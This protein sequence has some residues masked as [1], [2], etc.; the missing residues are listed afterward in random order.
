[1]TS[2]APQHDHHPTTIDETA[3][4]IADHSI[5][6]T[7]PL[8]RAWQLHTDIASWPQWLSAVTEARIDGPLTPGTAFH[9]ATAGMSIESTVYAVDPAVH[10]I[11]WGGPAHGITGIHEWTFTEDGDD[12]VVRTRES[13]SG[14]PVDADRTT[15]AAALDD[16]LTTWLTALKQ[17]AE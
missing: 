3:P 5:R 9:W 12:V 17:A 1:M 2:T 16:A 10:R 4:V 15:L 6:I 13:W 7:A 14:A 11:L 8:D